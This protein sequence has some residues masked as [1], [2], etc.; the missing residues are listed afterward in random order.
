[1]SRHR[2]F[3]G[4]KVVAGSAVGIGF[5]AQIF[6]A[7]GYTIV[8][9]ALGKAMGWSIGELAPGATLFLLAQVAGYPIV[10]VLLDRFGTRRVAAAGIVAFGLLLLALSRVTSIWQF[11]GLMLVMGLVGPATYTLSYLRALSLWFERRRGLAIGLAAGGI[12][13]GAVTMP[14]GLQRIVVGFDW[15]AALVALALVELLLCLPIVILLVRDDPAELGLRADGDP[16]PPQP[17][18]MSVQPPD[19]ASVPALSVAQALRTLDFWML[20]TVYFITGLAV[21]GVITNTVYILSE[22]AARLTTDQVAVVQ[23]VGGAAVL[24]GR[25]AGGYALDHLNTRAIAAAMVLLL[26]AALLGYAFASSLGVVLV[27]AMALGF[28]T[29]GE[30]DVLPYMAIKYFGLDAF[31]KIY[32]LLGALFAIGTGLGPVTYAGLYSV[33][34]QPTIP[35]VILAASTGASSLAFLWVGRRVS[36]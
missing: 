33:W 17:T 10:G 34:Q 15:S 12:A 30:G 4:W 21:Y 28:A 27:S 29:G 8:A 24:V 11:Y 7:S 19:R 23:A 5:S 13:L 31:G 35:L 18:K 6:I 14:V 32:G 1:M 3:P 22:T 25:V 2:V 16:T 26:T 20:G 36:G 9:A